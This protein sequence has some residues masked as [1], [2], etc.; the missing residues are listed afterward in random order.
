MK[1]RPD[2]QKLRGGYYTPEPIARFL[3]RW[4]LRSPDETVLE[5]SSGDGNI[6]VAA[7]ERLVSLGAPR[8]SLPNQVYG[9][10]FDEDEAEKARSRLA[11]AGDSMSGS[12]RTGDFF[13]H[14]EQQFFGERYFGSAVGQRKGFD[15][16]LGN[17]PF[18]R[19]Q[20]F[21]E[22]HRAAA[23]RLLESFGFRPNRLTN[24]WLPF[25]VLSSF[26]LN[27]KGR[28]ALVIPAELFQVGYAAEVRRFLSDYFRNLTLVTFRKL[29][30]ADAQQEVILLLGERDGQLSEG[31]RTVELNDAEDL[32]SFQTADLERI[33][34]K[35][36]DHS[37]EKWTQYFLTSEEIRLLRQLRA[38]E[39]LTR[40]G[41]VI[42]VDVGV[43]TGN[44]N[45]FILNNEQTRARGLEA[46]VE[47]I[48]TRSAHLPGLSLT[49]DDWARH[50]EKL[51]ANALFLPKIGSPTSIPPE[52]KA[53]IEVGEEGQQHV[54]YKCRIRRQWYVVPSVWVPDAFMLRQV[55]SYPKIVVNRAGA[56]CTDTIHRVRFLNGHSGESVAGA[57]LNSLTF[58]FSEVTGRSYGGGV[59][60]FEPSETEALPIPLLNA[61]L[62]DL[63]EIDRLL[64]SGD[65]EAVLNITDRVLLQGGLGLSK[66]Q[67]VML[68][69]IWKKLR[70]RRI[71]RRLKKRIEIDRAL[72]SPQNVT[73][74]YVVRELTGTAT[75]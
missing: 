17:P 57:F 21:P 29:L 69:G 1:A 65:I 28:L 4:A 38:D 63:D 60:T 33:E 31:I 22:E 14:A 74:P 55:H 49:E 43:V 25:V 67:V 34:I 56:T 8:G 40:S 41:E 19:Y 48:V 9:I 46:H 39:R 51:Y 44:N 30:F 35:P 54:G 5:P 53:Y 66:D 23:F 12:V 24:A 13:A 36:M 71:N 62:L 42:D 18:I 47:R 11:K 52:V 64:R 37:T 7:L 50:T 61:Q 26:L 10:E 15:A 72:T 32:E 58:A 45:Y 70:D 20:N 59:M 6:L 75:K 3:A 68:R 16:V 27:E 2:G 73:A